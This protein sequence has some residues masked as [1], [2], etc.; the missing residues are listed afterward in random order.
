ME[1]H[2]GVQLQGLIAAIVL[3][4]SAALLYDVLRPFRVK[5]RRWRWLI[6]ALDA[7]YSGV[8][9]LLFLRLATSL[10]QGQLRLYMLLG[11]VGGALVWWMGPGPLWR[12][13]W[14]FWLSSAAELVRKLL[15]P[16]LWVAEKLK[17]GFSFCVGWVIIRGRVKRSA[18]EDIP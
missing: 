7:L 16:V 9:M 14:G 10:G 2:V 5:G 11:G 18:E 17:K 6:H 15:R 4:M 1:N 3:G 8:A 12:Q 13:I